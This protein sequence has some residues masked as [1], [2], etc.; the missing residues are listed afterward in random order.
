L[1]RRNFIKLTGVSMASLVA[2][3]ERLKYKNHP[4]WK[5]VFKNRKQWMKKRFLVERTI[6]K[7]GRLFIQYG[8]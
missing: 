1:E 5:L 6:M 4:G 7:D 8:W 3:P 2:K